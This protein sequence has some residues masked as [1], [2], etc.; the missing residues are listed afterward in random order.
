MFFNKTRNNEND[1]FFH[2]C[3]WNDNNGRP[4]NRIELGSVKPKFT[5]SLNKFDTY[6]F[7]DIIALGREVFYIG[8]EQT[9]NDN[10]NLGFDRNNNSRD[11]IFYDVGNGWVNSSFKGSLMIR[12]VVGPALLD[13]IPIEK[14]LPANLE[15]NPNPPNIDGIV[16]IVL[17]TG[18]SSHEKYQYLTVR[19]FDIYGRQ[20]YSEPYSESVN[21]SLL[22]YG[23]YIV[24]L[25]DSAN[26]KNYSAKL[27]IVK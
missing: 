6:I 18:Y 20:V 24:N 12:P 1:D 4:G 27:M 3:L 26:S 17:P 9:S 8:W 11:K 19:I 15:I 16:K 10:L 13:S 14:S 21:V 25:Y 2:I 7:E 5:N 23:L 22:D